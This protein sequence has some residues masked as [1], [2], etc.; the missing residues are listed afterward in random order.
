MEKEIIIVDN[1]EE[2][3]TLPTITTKCPECECTTAYWWLRQLR[4]ADES[5]VRFFRCTACGKTW[6]E[7]D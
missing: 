7:Y 1:V 2:V 3:A 6:R 4:A 5:E